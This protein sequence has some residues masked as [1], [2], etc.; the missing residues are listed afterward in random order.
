MFIAKFSPDGTPIW[1]RSFQATDATGSTL[2][3]I[4]PQAL[5]TDAQG[6]LLLTGRFTGYTNLGGNRLWAGPTSEELGYYGMFLARFSW[7]GHHL[8]S[9]DFPRDSGD[10]EGA[11]LAT[12]ASGNVFLGG[13]LGVN[14]DLGGGR[15]G[16]TTA[17][18]PFVA[19]YSPG[20]ALL[21]QRH[22]SGYSHPTGT[23]TAGMVE[24]LAVDS[25]TGE[26]AL[27]GVMYGSFTWSGGT[28]RLRSEVNNNLI[29]GVL[30]PGGGDRW[31]KH[32]E[33]VWLP[34]LDA[35]AGRLV[36]SATQDKATDLGGGM[37]HPPVNSHS[38]VAKYTLGGTFGWA[39]V[40]ANLGPV[41]RVALMPDGKMVGV[42]PFTGHAF[43]DQRAW[44][45]RGLSDLLFFNVEP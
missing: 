28:F 29:L 33:H 6:S 17:F 27:A 15:L 2:Y 38:F 45:S 19:K 20:G 39:R 36:L 30:S 31:F 9:R 8:W 24:S 35:E 34:R 18:A 43:F 41:P 26:V 25:A 40:F 42:V 23:G 13:A 21:W 12:D 22:W 14:S 10:S 7:E 1:S 11:A 5:A 4:V 37:L 32:L 16:N 3:F 44:Y